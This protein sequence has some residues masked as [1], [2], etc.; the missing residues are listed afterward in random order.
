[1]NYDDFFK[2][3]EPFLREEFNYAD[4]LRMKRWVKVAYQY[5]KDDGIEYS[6]RDIEN[7]VAALKRADEVPIDHEHVN[8]LFKYFIN[9]ND[10]YDDITVGVRRGEISLFMSGTGGKSTFER[11]F[12]RRWASNEKMP[13]TRD[14]QIDIMMNAKK[15]NAEARKRL[16]NIMKKEGNL[17]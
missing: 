14:Q 4:V 15:R 17:K 11:N 12:P 10:S 9:D 6:Y 16:E 2:K 1:M 8:E 5:G 13:L 7:I 3:L